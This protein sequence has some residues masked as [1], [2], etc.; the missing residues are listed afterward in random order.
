VKI[1]FK[2]TFVNRLEDQ[3]DFIAQDSP[4]KARQFKND[5]LKKFRSIS[6]NPYQC[7]KSVYFDN[8]DTQDFI[9]KGYTIVFRI[10]KDAIEVFGF[11]KFQNKPD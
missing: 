11:L 7:R 6:K 10:N 3:I 8:S 2:E 5:L 4:A 1:I 9:F